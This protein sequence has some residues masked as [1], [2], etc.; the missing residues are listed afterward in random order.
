MWTTDPATGQTHGQIALTTSNTN[1]TPVNPATTWPQARVDATF[2]ALVCDL[3]G[4]PQE[5]INT[6]TGV[7]EGHTTQ[8][9]YGTRTWA[10]RR[11]S[12]L[13]FAG[14]YEDVESGWAYNRFRYYSPTLGG[15]NAQ[16]PLGLAPRLASAQ[17][18]VD[19]AAYWVDV[20]G[21]MA[22]RRIGSWASHD[23]LGKKVYKSDSGYLFDPNHVH[24]GETNVERMARGLA[25]KGHDGKSIQL[26]HIGQDDNSTLVELTQTMHKSNHNTLHIFN[27][28]KSSEFP[29]DV[30]PVDRNAFNSWKRQYWQE[31]AL[32]FL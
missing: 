25:P 6:T 21:L 12:P 23:V 16:D 31:R 5:L 28:L 13:L 27:G 32:D 17:G 4:A 7:I 14:Q 19:H 15:Y 30:T 20:L 24:R 18:Y 8:T 10:G 11:T 1:D 2:Y 29:K 3:A 22:H 26:H 9:L